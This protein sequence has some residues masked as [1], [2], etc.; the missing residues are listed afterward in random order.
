M[1]CNRISQVNGTALNRL[2][3]RWRGVVGGEWSILLIT[4]WSFRDLVFLNGEF[5]RFFSE[6]LPLLSWDNM[7]CRIWINKFPFPTVWGCSWCLFRS[8]TWIIWGARVVLWFAV[9][10]LICCLSCGSIFSRM[11]EES[12]WCSGKS[13]IF[14]FICWEFD[15]L[16]SDTH[17]Q[18]DWPG[19]LILLWKDDSSGNVH[20]KP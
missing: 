18:F 2:L 19:Y 13:Q 20:Q 9:K 8:C 15:D 7:H 10:F 17:D 12:S 3:G 4:S 11:S 16:I 6:F 5:L 1:I 14:F